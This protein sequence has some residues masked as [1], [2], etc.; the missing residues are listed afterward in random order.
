MSISNIKSTV[1][2]VVVYSD[3]VA[4]TKLAKVHL[5]KSCELVFTDLPGS[6]DD[7]SVRI[8]AK[9]L[10]VGEVQVKTG[11]TE[12]L[13]PQVKKI[14]EKI[15]A[16]TISD[17]TLSDEILVLQDKQKF[18]GTISVS[19]PEIISKELLAGKVAPVSWRQALKFI[20][21]EL[22]RAKNRIAEIER[23]RHRLKEQIDAL[24]HEMNDVKAVAQN[25]K[26]VVFDAE[27]KGAKE[28]AVELSYI[29]YGASWRPYYELRAE[30]NANKVVLSYFGKI[31]QRT[32][33]DWEKT[34]V[35]LSTGKPALG[36]A[37]PEPE[38]WYVYLYE[39]DRYKADAV[40]SKRAAQAPPAEL[41]M[42]EAKEEYEMA[43]P[44]DT[45]IAVNYPLPGRHTLKSGEAEKKLMIYEKDF[46]AEFEYFVMPR[47][48]ELAYS[49]GKFKNIT[50]YFFL[51]GDCSTYV[52]DDFTGK[53]YVEN[54]AP[55]ES[56]TLSFGVDER[57]KVERKMK[58]SKVSKG[59]IVKK[60]LLYE[61]EYENLIQNFHSKEVKCTIVD[62]IPIAGSADIKIGDVK[63]S[64]KP[65]EEEKERGL[66][67]WKPTIGAGKEY[68]IVVSFSVEI[69]VD[70]QIE[71]L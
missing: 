34:R 21:D 50:D 17:R 27:P 60:T 56:A 41:P 18:L 23:E 5:D 7:Q 69:P 13:E 16:L 66:Y 70:S 62:Q 57:V 4:V 19:T 58:K 37:A 63:F 29:I 28:Y 71:G 54:I 49:T 51:A 64:T 31:S 15:K 36:G 32:G 14:K 2:L 48:A 8:K 65:S 45:G 52:G 25:R 1:D 40:A 44:V 68:K 6:F 47:I 61:F 59:G 22:F 12:Q 30:P 46:A 67:F 38:P 10:T 55:D 39:E 42:G 33:E 9:G 35:A 26:T 53:L 11:Y 20:G 43:P 3:R 24:K